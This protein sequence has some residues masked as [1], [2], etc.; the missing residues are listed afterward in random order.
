MAARFTRYRLRTTD[1]AAAG[2]FYDAV[3]GHRGDGIGPLPPQAAARGAPAHW[4]G[5][6]DA[7]PLGGAAALVPR[8]LARGFA[9]L[10]APAEGAPALLRDPG[11]AI[12]ALT[13]DPGPSRAGVGL[14][15]L[16]TPDPAAAAATGREVLG[17]ASGAPPA[18]AI[19]ATADHPGAH[20]QWLFFFEVPSLAR[21]LDAVRALGGAALPAQPLPDGRLIS[22]CEDPQRAAFGLVEGGAPG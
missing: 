4:L 3:L 2:A 5:H 22:A 16:L 9:R 10:G 20:P 21:A 6:L 18:G 14:H 12:L 13:D 17:W 11:G 19:R 7:T 8:L 15:L 1:P